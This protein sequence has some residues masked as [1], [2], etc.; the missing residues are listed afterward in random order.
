LCPTD[1]FSTSATDSLAAFS[2]RAPF[3][4]EAF[5]ETGWRPATPLG[6]ASGLG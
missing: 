4:E 2:D 5:Y 1:L 3:P 6:L